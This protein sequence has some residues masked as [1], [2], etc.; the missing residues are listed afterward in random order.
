M[1]RKNPRKA[2]QVVA[3]ALIVLLSASAALAVDKPDSRKMARQMDVMEQ[4]LNQV[5]IDSPNFLVFGRDYT[6]ALYVADFGMIFT[7]EASLV[8]KDEDEEFDWKKFGLEGFRIETDGERKVIVIGPEDP[9]EPP[10]APEPP[11]A[12]EKDEDSARSWEERRRS[13]HD[14]LYRRGKTELVDVLLD[15]GDTL[16]T[17]KS[18][19][20]VAI[21]AKLIDSDYFEDRKI[22]HLVLKAK[23]SDLRDYAAEKISEK[24]MVTRIVETEY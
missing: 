7:F 1:F 17:L 16:T 13:K 15:Y 3:A 19:Q 2:S 10:D 24:E 12:G 18:N 23:I 11:K 21:V 5:L 6:H 20:R 9:P 22:S 4:I 14:R 8:G